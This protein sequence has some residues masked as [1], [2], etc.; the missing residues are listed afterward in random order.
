MDENETII[1]FK[2]TSDT[3]GGERVEKQQNRIIAKSKEMGEAS[4]ASGNASASAMDKFRGTMG[5]ITATFGAITA[6]ASSFVTVWRHLKD[7]AEAVQAEI[8][9][10]KASALAASLAEARREFEQI[11]NHASEYAQSMA[12]ADQK[13]QGLLENSRGLRD[14]ELKLAEARELAAIDPKDKDRDI[15][16][17]SIQQR[18][19]S[20]RGT[21]AATDQLEDIANKRKANQSAIT[22]NALTIA[23][24]EAAAADLAGQEQNVRQRAQAAGNKSVS[25]L[26]EKNWM[27]LE[28]RT[29]LGFG[30]GEESI[31]YAQR[32]E[33]LNRTADEIRKERE[34]ISE[35][36]EGLK[37]ANEALQ[38]ENDLLAGKEKI[39]TVNR[40]A[41]AVTEGT[42]AAATNAEQT[43]RAEQRAT[44]EGKRQKL[45]G[46]ISSGASQAERLR[47][48]IAFHERRYGVAV[49]AQAQAGL[50]ENIARGDTSAAGRE[51]LKSAQNAKY[52]ADRTVAQIAAVINELTAKLKA[53]E[54][55]L[56][57]D[58]SRLAT[59][60]E[61]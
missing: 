35:H 55:G 4:R 58:R 41:D 24:L 53:V 61:E 44:A 34:A 27:G 26:K 10:T 11:K 12:L 5:K 57:R 45:I 43:K 8:E 20:Q 29:V 60:K 49:D 16:I 23:D 50:A 31:K 9:K 33:E 56:K 22:S 37:R 46:D 13:Q 2:T 51:G 25:I 32:S 30:R 42:A 3:S 38:Q 6:A 15:K 7:V 59:A 54:D 52:Q 48:Q 19:S 21:N 1:K 47:A 40:A 39:I 28:G 17:Q 18:Y 14:A 36:I